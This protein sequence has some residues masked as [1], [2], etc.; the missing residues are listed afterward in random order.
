MESESDLPTVGSHNKGSRSCIFATANP[1][2]D[3]LHL[4]T[5]KTRASLFNRSAACMEISSGQP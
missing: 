1:F 5:N 2:K 4:L 3:N